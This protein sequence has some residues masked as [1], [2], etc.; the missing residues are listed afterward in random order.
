MLAGDPII[1]EFMASNDNT[2]DDGNGV[3]SDWIEIYNNGDQ[4]VDLA[5][6][7]LTDD[8]NDLN[9]WQ[10]PSQVLNPGEYLVV[11][12]SG[13]NTPDPAGNLHTNFSLS[14]GGEYLALVDT[15]ET[16]LSEFGP[17]GVDYPSQTTD[18]SYGFAFNANVSEV[19][20][21]TSN[22]RYLIP[23][24]D[25]FDSVWRD[26]GFDD[27][28]W[29]TGQASIGYE[30]TPADYDGLILTTV[31]TGTTSV[32][33]RIQFSV[34][35]PDT[36]LNTLQM[37]YDDGFIAYINGMRVASDNAPAPGSATYES[38]AT[39][40]HPDGLA[41]NYVDFDVSQ[42]SDSLVVGTNTLAIHMLNRSGSS[43][44]LA[45]PNLILSSG[46]LI[47]PQVTGALESPT[48]G[49]PNTNLRASDV[50]FS[51]VGG[52]FVGSFQLAMTTPD[53]SETIRY[54]TDGS[55]PN[56]S[57]PVYT[58]PI[59]V[60]STTQ[61]RA[62]AF[63]AVGQEGGITTEAYTLTAGSTGAFTSDLP[64]VVLEN[65]AQG[66]PGDG[67]FEDA[68]LALYEVDTGSGRSALANTADVT[69]IIGQ[70]RRGSSTAGNPKTNLRIELR[71]NFGED[72]NISLLG[73]PSESDW[74][75][76]AP[77][78]FDRA[79]M[80]NTTFFELSRQMGNYAT[81]TRFVEV[82]ANYNNGILDNSD[83][84]GVYVLQENI[85]RDKNRVDIADLSATQNTEPDI[86]GGYII[87]L[88]RGDGSPDGSWFTDR[89]IPTLQD[90]RLVHDTPE[91]PDMTIA[92]RDYI[93]GY[94]QDFEDAL[95]GPNSTDPVLGYE[96]YFDVDASIDH[97]IVRV[98]SKEPDSLR[99]S[100]FLTK[101]RGGKLAFG[102]VWDFDR[103][104][105][106]DN[107]GRAANPIGFSLPDVDFFGSDWWGPLF[108]DPD[109]M[110]RWVDRW[111]ELR[112]TVLT[113]ANIQAVIDA[114]EAQLAEAHVRNFNRWPEVSPNGGTYAQ[115]GLS[116]WEAEVSHL[117][118]WLILRANWID[119]QLVSA[120][121]FSPN[122]GN[123]SAGTQITLT[124]NPV[125]A[126]IYYTLDGTDPRAEGGGV[127]PSAVLYS[128]P[129][130]ANSTE[131]VTARSFGTPPTSSSSNS[132][133]P[134]NEAPS[135]GIDGT[136]FT[137]YLN[138]GEE[139]SGII[140]TPSSGSSIV[141]SIRL[142]TA[143]DAEERDPS[144]YEIYGTNES[145]Q[146]L[147]NSTGLAENWTLISS[148]SVSMPSTRF[149]NAPVLSFA[150]STAYSSY[151]LMFPTV[152]NAGAANSMQ[153][154]EIQFHA[155][156]NGTG[157]GIISPGDNALAVHVA[158]GIGAEGLS[159]WSPPISGLFSVEVPADASSLRITEL[160]YHPA[161]PTPA[162]LAL[163][164]GTGDNDYEFIELQNVSDDF[165]SLNN[166]RLSG[167]ITFDFTTANITSL[168]PGAVVVVVDQQTAF[169]ARYGTGLPVAGGFSGA[170]SNSME[171]V[172]L[173]DAADQ[174]IHDFTYTD[175]PPWPVGAD[176][177]GP[178][179]EVINPLGDLSD[180]TNWRVSAVAGGTPGTVSASVGDFDQDGDADGSDFLLWQRNFGAPYN[181]ADLVDWQ[182]NYCQSQTLAASIAAPIQA[183]SLHSEIRAAVSTTRDTSADV[184]ANRIGPLVVPDRLSSAKHSV[185]TT[186]PTRRSEY[187]P[188]V[189][190]A[191]FAHL[192]LTS[193][194]KSSPSQQFSEQFEQAEDEDSITL[195][196]KLILDQIDGLN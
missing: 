155:T 69:T 93:R 133:Y 21:P 161:D 102:P 118:N 28:S 103:S 188:P 178:S 90:S 150:N 142:T 65:F 109:F 115:A 5:G 179:I 85:K 104:S 128:G 18:I 7:G 6:Y 41:V 193:T 2:L 162:E 112:Q 42:H 15:N 3:S 137:K 68:N 1:T 14:A 148:G 72:K 66:T 146:S 191:V 184:T 180:P 143:N 51:R 40:E 141:R 33:V 56:A 97:H 168:A 134:A 12:A 54:T 82:Y 60:N 166:V 127:S 130:T 73:M 17:G 169:E 71:D 195:R 116:G 16:I 176:G 106:A 196:A 22:A 123:V 99:L 77:Y 37:K 177:D 53:A 164:P 163:A 84:M 124:A 111:R 64:I 92:Q 126:D 10:F 19:V 24:N 140:V 25:S 121:V 96:A 34:T 98:L 63:G 186:V 49:L 120:P 149:A 189:I 144:S 187:L 94:V 167:A 151:K 190:D 47:E 62:R 153:V 89:N 135:D 32:Y 11:F 131:Q 125:D 81:R 170:F 107:D 4:S 50:Q 192:E 175:D 86:T 172:I 13:N 20:T 113:D 165:I 122:P 87:R 114:Q 91:R 45:V 173:T 75:L 108:D 88:D 119:E 80:R 156:S 38:I 159:P 59:T 9:K 183:S 110:Q 74:I 157:T 79:M 185:R 70:H 145:I 31:P 48:P 194:G 158:T 105:G 174:V 43:D 30:N 46:G 100:T 132:S 27:G 78:N 23:T 57:S 52:A 139:N 29:Q 8:A 138:F 26:N 39:D 136:P 182:S 181:A 117:A 55:L 95:F 83:Y 76:Y 58:A 44:L 36:V 152:K 67:D 101:D 147:D 160:H 61:Y 154:G 35:D 171:Q 129:I